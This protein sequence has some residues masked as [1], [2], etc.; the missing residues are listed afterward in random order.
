MRPHSRSNLAS[1][2]V[3]RSVADSR[4][5]AKAVKRSKTCPAPVLLSAASSSQVSSRSLSTDKKIRRLPAPSYSPWLQTRPM[6]DGL[7]SEP[8]RFETAADTAMPVLT[9][10][11]P[12][13][14]GAVTTSFDNATAEKELLMLQWVRTQRELDVLQQ[15]LERLE[16]VAAKRVSVGSKSSRP[17][18][19]DVAKTRDVGPVP[20]LPSTLMHDPTFRNIIQRHATHLKQEKQRLAELIAR[21]DRKAQRRS[22]DRVV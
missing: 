12:N 9:P 13:V 16:S 14:V 11:R 21:R 4:K 22:D 19:A 18:E 7:A 1:I 2:S 5:L 8:A 20:E 17:S 15:E 6:A 3:S 10:N